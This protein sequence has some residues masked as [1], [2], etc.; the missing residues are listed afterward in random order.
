MPN[1]LNCEVVGSNADQDGQARRSLGTLSAA[2]A[3]CSKSKAPKLTRSCPAKAAICS[4]VATRILM[5]PTTSHRHPQARSNA[6][7]VL[8]SKA[9]S[10]LS[11]RPLQ[12]AVTLPEE[13]CHLVG[14][15]RLLLI[16][17]SDSSNTEV[18]K[19][20][21]ASRNE[22]YRLP[23]STLRW[24]KLPF[25]MAKARGLGVSF[26]CGHVQRVCCAA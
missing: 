14:R 8:C 13:H 18:T 22:T 26:L 23:R 19:P 9:T 17:Q 6:R 21:S 4:K 5:P 24:R 11:P 2:L 7:A 10:D 15:S 25:A 16:V 1:V 12:A 20:S 3:G